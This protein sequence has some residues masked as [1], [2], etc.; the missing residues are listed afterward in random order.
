[1]YG[2]ESTARSLCVQG[3]QLLTESEVFEDEALSG[4]KSRD[5]LAE[6]MTGTIMARSYSNTA[7][8]ACRQL[9]DSA[10]ARCFDE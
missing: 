9:V 4:N 2:G 8:R 7:N 6:E 5:N 10:S 3:E 1:M